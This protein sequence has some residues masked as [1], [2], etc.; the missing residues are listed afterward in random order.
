[1]GKLK[2]VAPFKSLVSYISVTDGE[3]PGGFYII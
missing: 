3:I 2:P 1:M